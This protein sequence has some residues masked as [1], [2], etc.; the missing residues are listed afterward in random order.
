MRKCFERMDGDD[1]VT[2]ASCLVK[3]GH[4]SPLPRVSRWQE[5]NVDQINTMGMEGVCINLNRLELVLAGLVC[6][7]GPLQDGA[8]L[9]K[10]IYKDVNKV[11]R[12]IATINDLARSA[13]FHPSTFFIAETY[14]K[15]QN[16]IVETSTAMDTGHHMARIQEEVLDYMILRMCCLMAYQIHSSSDELT[17]ELEGHIFKPQP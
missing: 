7:D 14:A 16:V 5:R 10:H 2:L 8:L 15:V 13:A 1:M 3:Y 6:H 4:N 11:N 17:K 9:Q 12:A